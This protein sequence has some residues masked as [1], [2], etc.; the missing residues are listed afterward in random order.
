MGEE[1]ERTQQTLH[2]KPKLR[3]ND[4]KIPNLKH[5]IQEDWNQKQKTGR[6]TKEHFQ[7]EFQNPTGILTTAVCETSMTVKW[8]AITR[9][10]DCNMLGR[11]RHASTNTGINKNMTVLG[12]DSIPTG[13]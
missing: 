3:N 7:K 2:T 12:N 5:L 13:M 10:A 6:S 4:H 1:D 11:Q 9:A 8:E